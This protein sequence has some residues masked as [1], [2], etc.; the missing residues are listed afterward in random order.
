MLNGNTGQSA[1]GILSYELKT[2]I[3]IVNWAYALRTERLEEKKL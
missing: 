3:A 1:A 2:H